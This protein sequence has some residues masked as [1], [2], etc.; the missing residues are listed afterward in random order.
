MKNLNRN[1]Y[2]FLMDYWFTS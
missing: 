2:L 1:T